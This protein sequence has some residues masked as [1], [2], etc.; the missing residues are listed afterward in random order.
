VDDAD[1]LRIVK[2]PLGQCRFTRVDVRA[3]SDISNLREIGDHF[4]M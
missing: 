2:N 4:G 1:P 3:D